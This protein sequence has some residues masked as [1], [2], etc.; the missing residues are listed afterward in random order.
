LEYDIRRLAS[1]TQKAKQAGRK[2]TTRV[3]EFERKKAADV[4]A[5]ITKLLAVSSKDDLFVF[6]RLRLADNI[7]VILER[8]WVPA[9]LCPELSRRAVR[10]SIYEF[11]T[12][13]Y[14]LRIAEADQTI[15][16]TVRFVDSSAV[17]I[18]FCFNGTQVDLGG[19]D[20]GM[21]EFLP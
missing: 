3:L 11:W 17:S 14:G 7:P 20:I 9:S 16:A 5:R 8:R 15:R 19:R 1:F 18:R 6:G 12:T 10:G 21:P 4:S 13:R 2:P